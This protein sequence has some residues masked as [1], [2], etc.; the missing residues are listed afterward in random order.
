M[1]R[2]FAL[3]IIRVELKKKK[4]LFPSFLFLLHSVSLLLLFRKNLYLYFSSENNSKAQNRRSSLSQNDLPRYFEPQIVAQLPVRKNGNLRISVNDRN[5]YPK[6]DFMV[7]LHNVWIYWLILDSVVLHDLLLLLSGFS[8]GFMGF[9]YVSPIPF[10]FLFFNK[11]FGLISIFA[12]QLFDLR[13][14]SYRA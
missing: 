5:R 4:F 6:F 12:C 2:I 9:F 7:F 11:F 8:F 1:Q 13:P 14:S 10:S 3:K